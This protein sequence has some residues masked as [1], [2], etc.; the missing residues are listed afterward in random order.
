VR[1]LTSWLEASPNLDPA[2]FPYEQ[3]LAAT[4]QVGKAHLGDELL[5]LLDKARGAL[6]PPGNPPEPAR[7]LLDRFLACLLDRW[8]GQF[9]APSYLA[10]P[11]LPTPD[12]DQLD[13]G[14]AWRAHDWL[15]V[16]LLADL[17]HFETT[18]AQTTG[19]P[20]PR[21]R[22]P[23]QLVAKRCRLAI[24]AAT[25][26][27]TR[28]RLD[29]PDPDDDLP[30]AVHTLWTTIAA[31]VPDGQVDAVRLAMLPVSTVHD[32]WLFI[33]VLQ[34]FEA[35]F[36]LMVVELMA[37]NTI[38]SRGNARL[39]A[40]FLDGTA[41]VL[42]EARPLFSLVA[43]MQP[44]AFAAFRVDTDGASAIQSRAAKMIEALCRR[45]DPHRLDSAAY[46][47]VP[48][49]RQRVL[50]GQFGFE[51]IY[52]QM[53]GRFDAGQRR[54]VEQAMAELADAVGHW[55]TTHY[56]LAVRLLGEQPGAGNTTGPSYLADVRG[57]PLFH[58]VT[59]AADPIDP[60]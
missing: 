21:L 28:L 5:V 12:P 15:L 42:R 49:V 52:L 36:A 4:H 13:L 59:P 10:L 25:P 55:R 60:A 43:T 35:S 58:T 31:A 38:L 33:R 20:L 1:D 44:Q 48:Q 40:I 34:C 8:D 3:I 6:P 23:A 57:I 50:D 39:A 37:A 24:R 27:L 29:R 47:S 17:L 7:L 54:R 16:H 18:A 45:P 22:P 19:V 32:E 56:R 51:D 11:L 26:A 41:S 14:A 46:R 30:D 53:A 2:R 9:D